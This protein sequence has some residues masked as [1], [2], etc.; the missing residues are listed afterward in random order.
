M[1]D[2]LWEEQIN[3]GSRFVIQS[4]DCGGFATGRFC[5]EEIDACEERSEPCFPG[6]LCIDLPPPA[7]VSGYKCGKCPAG[8]TGDGV[9]C[10]GE[11]IMIIIIIIIII[12]VIIINNVGS[13][14]VDHPWNSSPIVKSAVFL[15][16]GKWMRHDKQNPEEHQMTGENH[17][18]ILLLLLIIIIIVIIIIIIIIYTSIAQLF[19]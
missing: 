15:S 3:S 11:T 2:E 19:M 16:C 6:V 10:T 12:I 7:N 8:F 13:T 18:I 14:V 5:E 1:R 4:C 9:Q 17:I